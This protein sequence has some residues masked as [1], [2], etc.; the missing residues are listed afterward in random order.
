MSALVHQAPEQQIFA[1][2]LAENGSATGYLKALGSLELAQ[3]LARNEEPHLNAEQQE[4]LDAYLQRRQAYL[5]Y[6]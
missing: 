4:K 1:K 3:R 2:F 5:L 6:D